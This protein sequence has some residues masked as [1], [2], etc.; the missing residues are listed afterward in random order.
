ML[1]RPG[2]S[3]AGATA[4]GECTVFSARCSMYNQKVN[5]YLAENKDELISLKKRLMFG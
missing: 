4:T 5:A 1:R 3:F 2:V